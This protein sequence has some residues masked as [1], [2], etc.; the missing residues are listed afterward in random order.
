MCL[1][2]LIPFLFLTPNTLCFQLRYSSD[3]LPVHTSTKVLIVN[4]VHLQCTVPQKFKSSPL[5]VLFLLLCDKDFITNK[6]A[7]LYLLGDIVI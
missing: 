3:I 7:F 6:Y 4:I 2:A 1:D 5:S